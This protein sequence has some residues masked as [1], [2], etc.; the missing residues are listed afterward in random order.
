MIE[1]SYVISR[2]AQKIAESLLK[3]LL[4]FITTYP[5]LIILFLLII[6]TIIIALIALILYSTI[7][8]ITKHSSS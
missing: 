5:Y 8:W 1:D 4:D 6:A 2:A 7:K 3:L